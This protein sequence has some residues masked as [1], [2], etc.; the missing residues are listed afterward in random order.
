MR[1]AKTPIASLCKTRLSDRHSAVFPLSVNH[2]DK[3]SAI[4]VG[5]AQSPLRHASSFSDRNFSLHFGITWVD[6]SRFLEFGE[7]LRIVAALTVKPGHFHALLGLR[8][9]DRLLVFS[10]IWLLSLDD[11]IARLSLFGP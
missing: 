9:L 1:Y 8:P 7:G 4:E 10:W 5:A 6:F 2:A 3:V 11:A